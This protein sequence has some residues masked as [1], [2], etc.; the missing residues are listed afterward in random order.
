M[1]VNIRNV[2]RLCCWNWSHILVWFQNREKF[3]LRGKMTKCY[4]LQAVLKLIYFFC[5]ASINREVPTN[6]PF[7]IKLNNLHHKFFK[8]SWADE[9]ILNILYISSN[10]PPRL[11]IQD[12]SYGKPEMLYNCTLSTWYH[13]TIFLHRHVKISCLFYNFAIK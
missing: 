4:L 11:K 1:T 7:N 10:R 2:S 12:V 9:D 3:D 5:I 6:F 13:Q 8:M